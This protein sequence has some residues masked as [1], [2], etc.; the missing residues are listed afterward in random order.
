MFTRG[1]NMNLYI[2]EVN[3]KDATMLYKLNKEELF[4]DYSL[5]NTVNRLKNLLENKNNKIFVAEVDG[6]VVAYIHGA[7]YDL[8][9]SDHLKNIMGISVASEYKRKGIGALLLREIE[10]WA[11]DTGAVGIRI[12]SGSNRVSAHEFYLSCGYVLKKEQKSFF[13]GFID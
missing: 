10:K 11:K 2:R 13:K 12:N 4:Y 1:K 8:F 5:E 9:Y 3:L 6:E 7:D